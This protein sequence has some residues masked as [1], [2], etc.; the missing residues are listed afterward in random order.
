MPG[1]RDF[2]MGGSKFDPTA[3]PDASMPDWLRRQWQ[4][5]SSDGVNSYNAP[6]GVVQDAQGRDV[7]L[8][9]DAGDL[10]SGNDGS[11]NE[12]AL[13][14]AYRD[15]DLGLVIPA[16]F[17]NQDKFDRRHRR[18]QI[19]AAAMMAGGA[20][21]GLLTAGAA[22]AAGA[23]GIGAAEGAGLAATIP[24]DL[25]LGGGAAGGSAALAE[26]PA[27]TGAG[28]AGAGGAGLAGLGQAAAGGGGLAGAGGAASGGA[29]AAAGAGG[30]VD[31][32]GGW[33]N[34]AR[35]AGGLAALGASAGGGGGSG[36]ETN[37]QN[38]IEQMAAANRVDHN[39]PVGNRRWSQDP[40]T[41]RW[42]V[43]DSMNPAE[44]A[45]FE[46]VQG[47]NSNV[48]QAAR[49]R[50]AALLSQAPRQRYDRPL[51]T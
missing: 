32:L 7:Y 2:L 29:G 44:Q 4:A 40:A 31:S 17:V 8:M 24:G 46:G 21:G 36:G 14:H 1:F 23:G 10:V 30:L 43:N 28:T 37:P 39:T 20:A 19:M 22:G 15:P 13:E 34:I 5:I 27:I 11:I 12:G 33:Q 49:D 45:N 51:G 16:E 35:G 3:G 6:G 38:I 47:I 48:T 18:S 26:I 42:T 41:G 50:L 25:A 9:N